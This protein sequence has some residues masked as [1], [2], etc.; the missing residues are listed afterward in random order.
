MDEDIN[1]KV[2][3]DPDKH[4]RIFAIRALERL[5]SREDKEVVLAIA[6]LLKDPDREVRDSAIQVLRNLGSSEALPSL[7]DA[8][9]DCEKE[10]RVVIMD[11]V[12]TLAGNGDIDPA[13][14][15]GPLKRFVDVVRREE[16][17]ETAKLAH[18]FALEIYLRAANTRKAGMPKGGL[19][20]KG[21]VKPP[22]KPAMYHAG[23]RRVR[24]G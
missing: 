14:I 23:R 16:G 21:T 24:N 18:E 22:K 6:A 8:L 13:K 10:S 17:A 1:F 9:Q 7:I 4:V 20:S 11:I 5:G 15:A 19:L 3:N 12:S 2:L